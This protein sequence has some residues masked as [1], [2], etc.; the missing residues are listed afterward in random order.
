MRK[1]TFEEGRFFSV[2]SSFE[3]RR[4]I[5]DQS[6]WEHELKWRYEILVGTIAG[7]GYEVQPTNTS[8]VNVSSISVPIILRGKEGCS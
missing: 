7:C 4:T 5:M 8:L 3:C 2:A 1:S 6:N